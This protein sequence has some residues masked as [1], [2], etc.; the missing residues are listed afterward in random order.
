MNC[1]QFTFTLH[2]CALSPTTKHVSRK[3]RP[4]QNHVEPYGTISCCL[5]GKHNTWS[6]QAYTEACLSSPEHY[7]DTADKVKHNYEH[8]KHAAAQQPIKECGLLGV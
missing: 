1:I 6:A 7:E 5:N 2:A 8:A 3:T 4:T